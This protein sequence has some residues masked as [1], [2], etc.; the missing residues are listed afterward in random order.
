MTRQL[1]PLPRRA[2]A[3]DL[4]E[5]IV[6]AVADGRLAPGDALP[7]ESELA[8]TTR[9]SRL[10]VRE[11]IKTLR[12]KGVVR[13]EQGRG[14][15][16]NPPRSWSPLDP[17]LLAARVRVD[18]SVP[19]LLLTVLEARCLVEVGVA[20]LAA[21]RRTERDLDEIE[22][23]LEAMRRAQRRADVPAFVDADMAFHSAIF[24]AAGNP[25]VSALFEPIQRLVYAARVE[26]SSRRPART[27]AIRHHG[28][29]LEALRAGDPDAARRAMEDHLAETERES[30]RV[31]ARRAVEGAG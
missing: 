2:L 16:V 21:A 17:V 31:V 22:R 20:G 11:A 29:I 23:Q 4:V 15:F 28:N 30:K 24:E 5:E 7:P 27:R 1:A 19:E 9:V 14:T 25:L 26:T 13:V 18:G 10:T 3:D 12:E 8:R 6:D